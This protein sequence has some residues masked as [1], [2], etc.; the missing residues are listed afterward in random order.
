MPPKRR[1]SIS[2]VPQSKLQE[3]RSQDIK[4]ENV[5]KLKRRVS[6]SREKTV[7][8]Y[9][10]VDQQMIH[11]P[12]IEL[13]SEV[14]GSTEESE[15][16]ITNLSAANRN[17][18]TPA[19][20]TT[21]E[22]FGS[23]F[24]ALPSSTIRQDV[25][26]EFSTLSEPEG[27]DNRFETTTR[28]FS[29]GMGVDESLD[30]PEMLQNFLGNPSTTFLNVQADRTMY[31][32]DNENQV[33]SSSSHQV[34]E[35]GTS[36]SR[37]KEHRRRR[38]S[39][40]P[41]SVSLTIQ[42]EW[43][44]EAHQKMLTDTKTAEGRARLDKSVQDILLKANQSL[45]K[46]NQEKIT[47]KQLRSHMYFTSK[48]RKNSLQKSDDNCEGLNQVEK[49]VPHAYKDTPVFG[50]SPGGVDSLG[51]QDDGEIQVEEDRQSSGPSTKC[52][53][54]SDVDVLHEFRRLLS[55]LCARVQRIDEKCDFIIREL[56]KMYV[57]TSKDGKEMS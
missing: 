48:K 21:C 12:K 55:P 54:K 20:D 57:M 13:I 4:N 29:G 10:K 8:H 52:T 9:D 1:T 28:L 46:M 33:G 37:E 3:I 30:Q 41:A 43:Y 53:K 5:D 39:Q 38:R 17:T 40:I 47:E 31:K 15:M 23:N 24:G 26:M 36:R 2:K 14:S 51:L 49:I 16:S 34:A 35:D 32:S 6:F 19:F 44:S 42:Q 22:L 25:D 11:S 27:A 7:Q 50:K 56:D 18:P 45:V